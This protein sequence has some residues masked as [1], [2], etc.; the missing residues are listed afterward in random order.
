MS[1]PIA[2]LPIRLLCDLAQR[3]TQPS[4]LNT[5]APP[6]FYRG[7][8]VEIDI[9]IGSAGALLAPTLTNIT[10]VTCQIFA[11]GEADT[12]APVMSR[13][14]LAAAMNLTLTAAQWTNNTTPF[15]HAAFI[16][17]N[18]QT[19][20]SLNGQASA[21]MW[22]RITLATADATPKN[23][24][25][26][27]CPITILDGPISGAGAVPTGNVRFW[28]VGGLSVLQ[29]R[30]DSDGKFYTLGVE[31]SGGVPTLYLSDVGY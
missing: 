4:D 3:G 18:A 21:N 11:G 29:V 2:V 23:I 25:L 26:L 17:P 8:D 14:V 16:F 30:N 7:D 1:T 22:L 6:V 24:T 15:Y 19:A 28:T 20:V 5:N 13:T 27:D 10:S 9:G 12:N 31:N